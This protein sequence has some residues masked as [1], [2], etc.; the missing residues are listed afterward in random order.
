MSRARLFSTTIAAAGGYV[1]YLYLRRRFKTSSRH[2]VIEPTGVE[3]S[4]ED[5]RRYRLLKLAGGIRAL[6]VSDPASE[7]RAT[8]AMCV[9]KAGARTAPVELVGL[10]HFLEHMLFLGSKK[11]PEES[12][13]KKQVSLNAGRCNASTAPED[14]VY[15]F[16]V[17]HTGFS[18]VLD[19]FAQFFVGSPL[20]DASAAEREV[21]AVTSE[22]SRNRVND[23]RRRRM[24]LQHSAAGRTHG[25]QTWAKFGTGNAT[26]LGT[27]AAAKAGVEVRP[28]LLCYR[29]HFYRT[30]AMSLVLISSSPLDETIALA[31]ETFGAFKGGGSEEDGG[32]TAA[33][34]GEID[35]DAAKAARTLVDRAAEMA[36]VPSPSHPWSDEATRTNPLRWPFELRIAP[37]K[38]RR[39]V[40]LY[41][42]L[43]GS[44][45]MHRHPRSPAVSYL[46]HLL[47]HEGEG[48]LFSCLQSEGLATAVSS[49]L[50]APRE[51]A[52]L[53]VSIALTPRGEESLE[54]VIT[55]VY[56]YIHVLAEAGGGEEAMAAWDERC[57]TSAIDFRYAER[58]DAASEAT[59]WAKRLHHY[60]G[61]YVLSGGRIL[62]NFPSDQVVECLSAMTPDNCILVWESK[63]HL[64][65]AAATIE[66]EDEGDSVCLSVPKS[67]ALPVG[68]ERLVETY[69]GVSYERRPFDASRQSRLTAARGGE[70]VNTTDGKPPPPLHLP[71]ANAFIASDFSMVGGLSPSAV[72]A[73][74]AAAFG[75]FVGGMRARIKGA[76]SS[77]SPPSPSPPLPPPTCLRD[78]SPLVH[79]HGTEVSF[80]KPKAHLIVLLAMPSYILKQTSYLRLWLSVMDQRLAVSL[81]PAHLAGLRWG[82]SIR[83]EGLQLTV[84]GFSQ[85]LP[86]LVMVLLEQLLLWDG[87]AYEP[88][89]EPKRELLVRQLLSHYK[90]TSD[91]LA[92]YHLDLLLHPT[93]VPV[94]VELQDARSVDLATL[95]AF[96]SEAIKRFALLTFT[97]GNITSQTATQL[98]S[99]IDARV[100]A[101]AVEPLRRDEWATSPIIRLPHSNGSTG[102]WKLKL[103]PVSEEEKNSG[104]I[105]YY[106]FGQLGMASHERSTLLLMMKLIE[107]PMFAELRTKQQLGYVVHSG[108]YLSGLGHDE[109]AGSYIVILSKSQPPSSLQ[110]AIDAYVVQADEVIAKLTNDE[111]LTSRTALVTRFREPDRTL[112]EASDRRWRPIVAEHYDWNAR[113]NSADAIEKVTQEDTIALAKRLV[114][115]P[116]IAVHTFG[117]GKHLEAFGD[118]DGMEAKEISVDGWKAWRDEREEWPVG[119][120]PA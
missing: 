43:P 36:R 21:Q 100:R 115:M 102:G 91:Q 66:E 103:K 80:A 53:S 75:R 118:K 47:G 82:F 3:R 64:G 90:R 56:E 12:Y 101:A 30:D 62:G 83:D 57:H 87:T 6:V 107:Q 104:C 20:L 86:D 8:A 44:M 5:A 50:E 25:A 7:K 97:Y 19:V 51:F 76:S 58:G 38:E 108:A 23:D 37:V 35:A 40:A 32:A 74:M 111:F 55:R 70:R 52:L 31:T 114:A 105:V 73:A 93:R 67:E 85:K 117:A 109:V 42:A 94:E 79:W 72:V 71:T 63:K 29:E 9:D 110:K 119:N 89:F 33:S 10:A 68:A 78:A 18:K 16:E 60:E 14:T 61:E 48:S 106:Q 1:I 41:W 27:E 116:R 39:S 28:A 77:S 46:T 24:V 81:Y 13:Y 22:D 49:G 69:Y 15:Y 45:S 59:N 34:A 26:T 113:A 2:T 99:K 120:R 54:L 88:L 65:G 84:R 95:Q 112:A 11:Y 4:V 96:H 17:F 92:M 98:I